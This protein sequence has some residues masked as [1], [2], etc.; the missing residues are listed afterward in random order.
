MCGTTDASSHQVY[1]SKCGKGREVN[2]IAIMLIVEI[3]SVRRIEANLLHPV[4]FYN[5]QQA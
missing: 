4:D 5:E 3:N 2:T 1:L